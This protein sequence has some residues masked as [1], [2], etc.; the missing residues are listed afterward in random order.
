MTDVFLSTTASAL[1]DGVVTTREKKAIV[2]TG[3]LAGGL[4]LLKSSAP[5]WLKVVG[6]IAIVAGTYAADDYLSTTKNA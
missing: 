4:A 3:A 2:Y 5:D 6:S 1:K